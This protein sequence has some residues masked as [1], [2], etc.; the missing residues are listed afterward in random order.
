MWFL[1]ETK[2][3]TTLF[4]VRYCFRKYILMTLRKI[5]SQNVLVMFCCVLGCCRW[6]LQQRK[7][8]NRYKFP[9]VWSFNLHCLPVGLPCRE[10]VA[11]CNWIYNAF[12]WRVK[13][14]EQGKWGKRVSALLQSTDDSCNYSVFSKKKR[15]TIKMLHV[16]ATDKHVRVTRRDEADA[17]LFPSHSCWC[18]F[19]SSV[20]A[21]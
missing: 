20:L 13:S 1:E 3:T 19:S 18:P 15:W 7:I 21:W 9:C 16:Q 5:Y 6:L 17:L 11:L 14:G 10:R 8:E 12:W 4:R 2:Q